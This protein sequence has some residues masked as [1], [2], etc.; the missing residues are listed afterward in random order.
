MSLSTHIKVSLC[1]DILSNS[2]IIDF[3]CTGLHGCICIHD[4]DDG[5][6]TL[7]HDPACPHVGHRA[8]AWSVCFAPDGETLLSSSDDGTVKSWGAATGALRHTFVVGA[9]VPR[10]SLRR[11][12]Q[13]PIPPSRQLFSKVESVS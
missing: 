6:V 1:T 12:R 11:G 9:Q 5:E 2:A 3:F 10:Q 8:A 13:K 7:A 4:F